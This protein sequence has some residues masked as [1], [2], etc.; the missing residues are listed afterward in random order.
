MKPSSRSRA[1]TLI[2]L[3][4]VIA[5]TGV[6]TALILATLGTVRSTARRV[7]CVSNLRQ[8]TLAALQY[9]HDRKDNRTVPANFYGALVNGAYLP[10]L[11]KGDMLAL[12]GVWMCPED[13]RDRTGVGD[14]VGINQLS[15]GYNAQRIGFANG[16]Y[17][18]V[19]KT[20]LH[21][22][23]NPSRTLYFSDAH[24]YY[25]DKA[26]ANRNAEFRHRGK[27]N[28]AFFD[29]HVSTLPQP[30]PVSGFYNDLF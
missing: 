30:T 13:A 12:N 11:T 19:S 28:V 17:W 27:I 25:M 7:R 18:E 29:G 20:A 16:G 9:S 24:P 22:I 26:P 10:K 14:N 8:I 3:L 5:I 4:A 15:C 2:E 6:L 1:F 21:E 23:P